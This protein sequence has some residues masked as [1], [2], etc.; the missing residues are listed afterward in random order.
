MFKRIN[1]WNGKSSFASVFFSLIVDIYRD[2]N[3]NATLACHTNHHL[4]FILCI[5]CYYHI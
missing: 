2:I 1:K 4:H 3:M 5:F